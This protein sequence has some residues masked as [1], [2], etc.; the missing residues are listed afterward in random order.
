MSVLIGHASISENG[1]T[2]GKAGDQTGREVYTQLWYSKPWNVM[3]I[4]TDKAI[5]AKA[6]QE[7]RFACA[8]DA[9][10]Y[11]QQGRRTAYENGKVNGCTFENAK[12]DTDCSQLIASC[13]IFAGL[14]ISPDCYT[15]NIRKALLATGKF[16]EY[17][18]AAHIQSDEYAEIGAVY[19]K[20]GSHT[21]MALENG[22]KVGGTAGGTQ[23][24]GTAI[25]KVETAKSK[26]MT[27][28]GTYKITAPALNL[29]TGAGI[30]K[31]IITEMP[32][33]AK[34]QCYGYHTTV[35]GVKW[36]YVVY[37]GKTGFASSQYLKK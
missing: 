5:A 27:L 15:G 35:S 12:G 7:M 14:N 1:T 9:I 31:D 11:N 30:N 24:A 16:K 19:L 22:S 32:N 8:N 34:V 23:A 37:N 3:L 26:D 18:D 36:L 2:T 25:K 29:R 17:T 6:A 21:V 20:E 4:C 13:Y 33:G 10:G 28:S